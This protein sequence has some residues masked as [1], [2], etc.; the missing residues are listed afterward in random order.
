MVRIRSTDLKSRRA[1]RN[2]S[3]VEEG[4]SSTAERSGMKHEPLPAW[5]QA[6][7]Q[8]QGPLLVRGPC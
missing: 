4:R 5:E 8:A 3:L 6:R 7:A 1:G 2:Q